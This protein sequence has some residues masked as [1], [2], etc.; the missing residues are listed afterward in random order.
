MRQS[1][2]LRGNPF[3]ELNDVDVRGGFVLHVADGVVSE[4]FFKQVSIR[5]VSADQRVVARA[6]D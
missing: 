2:V 3:A 6:A 5:S 1:N 4:S